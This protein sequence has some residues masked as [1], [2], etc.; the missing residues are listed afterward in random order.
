MYG[1]DTDYFVTEDGDVYGIKNPSKILSATDNVKG[2]PMVTLKVNDRRRTISVHKLVAEAFVYN[3]DPLSKN[4]INHKDGN[5]HNN[6]YTN[7]EWVTCSEN[8]RHAFRTGLKKPKYGKDH[9]NTVFDE[10]LIHKICK[11][12]KSG[13]SI[14]QI[15]KKLNI[16]NPD[17]VRNI[18][19]GK[20]WRHISSKYNIEYKIPNKKSSTTIENDDMYNIYIN[21]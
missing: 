7:L 17:L 15:K 9:P 11:S 18:I 6:H 14:K 20:Y 16:K 8:V 13:L 10:D 3:D 19:Q 2:Y 21:L 4:Q 5:K 12:Y 1:Y